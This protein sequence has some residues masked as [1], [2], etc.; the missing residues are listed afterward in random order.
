MITNK[1]S[2]KQSRRQRRRAGNQGRAEPGP[3]AP[4]ALM[5]N[6]GPQGYP[7]RAT[8]V[9]KYYERV[10]RTVTTTDTYQFSTNGMYDPNITGTGHQPMWFDQTVAIY[11]QYHVM[12]STI[13]YTIVAVN[14][15][16][17]FTLWIDD[18]TSTTTDTN[19]AEQNTSLVKVVLATAIRPT[20]LTKTWNAKDYFGGDILDNTAL[21]GS[22]A[23][24][25]IEQMYF[26]L[27]AQSMDGVTTISYTMLVTV[28][29]EAIWDEMKTIAQ[30]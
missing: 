9:H 28:T 25:P 13:S 11:D 14:T 5:I 1:R 27:G 24:N 18:D 15:P 21:Y 6:F 20:V 12:K 23:G 19:A 29:Y 3:N 26:T 22:S 8:I 30:S 10:I 17:M 16:T 4:Q 7:K 2:N